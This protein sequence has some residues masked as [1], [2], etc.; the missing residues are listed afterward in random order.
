MPVKILFVGDQHVQPENITEINL[1]IEKLMVLGAEFKP[2]RIVLAG[3]LCHTHEW[4]HSSAMNKAYELV[5]KMREIAKTFVL[6]GNHDFC[7]GRDV[8]VLL[9]NGT[10]K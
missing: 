6:V 10:T 4:V 9:W 2:D 1:L 5:K 7:L 3:D 8:P